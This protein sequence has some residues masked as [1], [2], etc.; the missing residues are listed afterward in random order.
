MEERKKR[1]WTKVQF[2]KKTDKT[3]QFITALKK[4]STKKRKEKKLRHK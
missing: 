1:S 3:D 4:N 2:N